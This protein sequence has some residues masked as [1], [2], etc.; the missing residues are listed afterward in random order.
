MR[1]CALPRLAPAVRLPGLGTAGVSASK[2]ARQLRDLPSRGV[3]DER[4]AH[5]LRVSAVAAGDVL[6][7]RALHPGVARATASVCP[8]QA[9]DNM[10]GTAGWALRSVDSVTVHRRVVCAASMSEHSEVRIAAARNPVCP[11]MLLAQLAVDDDD[12][13]RISAV[14]NLNCPTSTLLHLAVSGFH[15]AL[16]NPAM[17]AVALT[18]LSQHP[19]DAVRYSVIQNRACPPDVLRRAARQDLSP[20]VCDQ[21]L[22]HPSCPDGYHSRSRRRPRSTTPVD[23]AGVPSG[24][25]AAHTSTLRGIL[26]A[27]VAPDRGPPTPQPQRRCWHVSPVTATSASSRLSQRTPAAHPR[28][29][30]NCRTIPR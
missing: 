5:A 29:C 2:L 15:S 17:G 11:P 4:T 13:V 18:R 26:N 21:A 22:A 16:R 20:G 25:P 3:C 10:P 9:R 12:Y 7:H 23:G 27:G 8:Q 6:T 24:M 19:D 1:C 30:C 14:E 28:R